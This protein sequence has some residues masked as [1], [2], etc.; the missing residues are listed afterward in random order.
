MA[1]GGYRVEFEGT[2][3]SDVEVSHQQDRSVLNVRIAHAARV[4]KGDTYEDSETTWFKGSKWAK[5]ELIAELQNIAASLAK[6]DRV[7]VTGTAY[8]EAWQSRDG[9]KSGVS[10]MLEIDSITPSLR[11]AGVRVDRSRRG[12]GGQQSQQQGGGWGQQGQQ[13]A[14]GQSGWGQAA[15]P[16]QPQQQW[17]GQQPAAPQQS[18]QQG[19]GGFDDEQPF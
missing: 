15:A 11:F 7:R 9:Q 18:Q 16:A 13:Q 19:F 5:G 2:I 17:A 4:K 8:A 6:G 14:Q 12:G 3:G 10:N 1:F